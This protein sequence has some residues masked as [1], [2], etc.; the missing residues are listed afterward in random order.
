MKTLVKLRHNHATHPMLEHATGFVTAEGGGAA[1]VYDAAGE[2]WFLLDE[3]VTGV[4]VGIQID[5]RREVS[6][7]RRVRVADEGHGQPGHHHTAQR[8][9]TEAWVESWG[10]SWLVRDAYRV[11]GAMLLR[12]ASASLPAAPCPT[13]SLDLRAD[14]RAVAAS[15]RDAALG[16]GGVVTLD[17][18]LSFLDATAMLRRGE[19]AALDWHDTDGCLVRLYQH[20]GAGDCSVVAVV[21]PPALRGGPPPPSVDS[22]LFFAPV[23]GSAYAEAREVDTSQL[24]RY[25]RRGRAQPGQRFAGFWAYRADPLP[26]PDD[27]PPCRFASQLRDAGR[28]VVLVMPVAN[29]GS[30]SPFTGASWT[31]PHGHSGASLLASLL[32]AVQADGHLAGGARARRTSTGHVGVAGFSF[33]GGRALSCF[34]HNAP[35]VDELYLFD[36]NGFA[37]GD[38][39]QRAVA[40]WVRAPGR[41]LRLIGGMHCDGLATFAREAVAALGA[42]PSRHVDGDDDRAPGADARDRSVV[43]M[44]TSS[45]F[46]LRSRDYH[47][48]YARRDDPQ[49]TA[50]DAAHPGTLSRHAGYYLAPDAA[51]HRAGVRVEERREG[52]SSPPQALDGF[53]VD[54]AAWCLSL[55]CIYAGARVPTLENACHTMRAPRR[56]SIPAPDWMRH[57]WTVFG[58]QSATHHHDDS[59]RGYL[60]ICLETSGFKR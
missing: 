55:E 20:T 29:A 27:F 34:R 21:I 10:A 3:G 44:P 59:F 47:A 18:D 8:Y 28:K 52:A 50:A 22:L 56:G 51:G 36:P 38:A 37:P 23:N 2:W 4:T 58:G 12:D 16:A 26:E 46:F 11:S 15:G 32:K 39:D 7:E 43:A 17:V 57:Q 45:R 41:R 9:A 25:L 14:V 35:R 33:G 1:Q 5:Y 6:H 31:L 13:S 24:A 48:A 49:L 30:Y 60:Q 42:D 19:R 40:A 54:E 53:S